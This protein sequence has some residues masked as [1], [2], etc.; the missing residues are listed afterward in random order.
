MSP[1][2]LPKVRGSANG[3][4]SSRKISNQLENG[5]GFSNGCAEFALKNPPPLLPSSLMTS[6]EA[7]GPPTMVC[8]PPVSVLITWVALK[9]SITPVAIRMMAP[10]TEIGSS[11][12][13][14]TRVVSTQKL[15]SRSVLF[16]MKP[17]ISAMTTTMPTA[18][19]TKFCTA[20]PAIC[21][22]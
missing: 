3:M 19:D 11:T 13:M 5:F 22:T 18:A 7:T 6:C 20:R 15:P 21:T 12:R 8:W 17:R 2:I 14:M 9:L 1:T 10:I 16:R 4:T